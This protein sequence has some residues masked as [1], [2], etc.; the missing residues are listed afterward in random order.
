MGLFDHGVQEQKLT[1]VRLFASGAAV[2]LQSQF[3][4]LMRWGRDGQIR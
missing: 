3:A 2:K 4:K 1:K